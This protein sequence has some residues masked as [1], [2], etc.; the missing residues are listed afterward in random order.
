MWDPF[1]AA[2]LQDRCKVAGQITGVLQPNGSYEE[3][4]SLRSSNAAWP[5]ILKLNA[6]VIFWWVGQTLLRKP[7]DLGGVQLWRQE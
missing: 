4:K 2:F 1:F 7:A 3:R 6:I 5:M